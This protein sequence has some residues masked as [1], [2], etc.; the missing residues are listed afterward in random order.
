MK[1]DYAIQTDSLGRRFG[2]QWAVRHLGLEVP[3]GSVYGFLGLNGAGKSTTMRMLMGLLEPHEGEASVLGLD[4]SREP[5]PVRRRVGYVAD[6]AYMYEW[7]TIR[8]IIAF[9][10]HYRREH[11]DRAMADHLAKVFKLPLDQK[12]KT[13]SKGQA[14][15]VSLLLA[16][17][18]D[19]EMLILDE[20][21]GGLDPVVRR[22]FVENLLAEYMESGRTVFISSHLVNEI[23][24][25]V[26]RVGII[27][28]GELIRQAPVDDLRNEIKRARLVFP[29]FVPVKLDGVEGVLSIRARDREA[30]VLLERFNPETTPKALESC[31]AESVR[32][33]DLSLE[34]IFVALA[35]ERPDAV[36][37]APGTNQEDAA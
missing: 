7:M 12:I 14:A 5:L 29:E 4:P 10:A 2:R 25:L 11:W 8:E 28:D 21:T 36:A 20:P 6:R 22:E 17:G 32:I 9:V 1:T 26:D 35:E 37:S 13:L 18:F 3:R 19:P 16:M 27:K 34:D 24:G 30:A 23:A 33:E 15:K 31:G